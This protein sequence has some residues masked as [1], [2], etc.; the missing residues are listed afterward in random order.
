M[1]LSTFAVLYWLRRQR[2]RF[3]VR[4]AAALGSL[5]AVA[6]ALHVFSWIALGVI[7]PQTYVLFFLAAFCLGLNLWAV[8]RP[9]SLLKKLL[10]LTPSIQQY[11]LIRRKN[12]ERIS[13]H[14]V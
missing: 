9:A 10:L 14:G 5:C 13:V 12:R 1:L 7:M 4:L 6:L 2:P 3:E 8:A 11:R